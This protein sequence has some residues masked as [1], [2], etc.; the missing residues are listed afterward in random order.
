M[1]QREVPSALWDVVALAVDPMFLV[2]YRW[3][4]RK[5]VM[6]LA[7]LVVHTHGDKCNSVLHRRVLRLVVVVPV[8]IC[9]QF[10]GEC[11]QG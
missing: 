9:H 10:R 11:Y 7:C 5:A 3:W 6:A 4:R 2:H 8:V 1:E